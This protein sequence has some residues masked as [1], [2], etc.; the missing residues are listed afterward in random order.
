MTIIHQLDS[1][2]KPTSVAIIGA[3]SNPMKL[4]NWITVSAL[5]SK[6]KGKIY[7]VNPNVKEIQGVQTFSS[8]LDVPGE[9]DVAAIMVPADLVPDVMR[10]C[11]KKKV[12]GV[13]IFSAGFKEIGEK[14]KKREE[15][16]KEL[17]RKGN[18]RIVGPNCMGVYSAAV[19]LNLTSLSTHK[20]V[21]AFVSQS[22]GYGLEIFAAGMQNGIMFSKF[23]STGDKADIQDHEYLEYLY[24]DPDTKV[25][26]LY[27]EGIEKGRD[28][29]DVAKKVTQKKPIFAI[30]IGRS[31]VGRTAA[32]S[33]TGAL[34]GEEE[35]YNA[36]FKQAGIIRASDIE[37][38]FDY[39]R[40]Y[41]TQPL[42]KGNRV[43]ILVGSGGVGVTAADAC[44]DG[45]LQVPPL[46]K[47][48]QEILRAV[49][50]EFASVRNPVDFTGS[51]AQQLFG[52]WG[53]V[54]EI[55][56]DPTIDSWF[57]S[58]PGAGF[59]G[60]QDIVK[61]YEPIMAGLQGLSR[62]E[63]FGRDDAPFVA[64]GNEKDEIIK[65]LLEKLLGLLYYPTPERAIRSIA[66]LHNY[67]RFLEEAKM[68]EKP[69]GIKKDVPLINQILSKSRL[70]HRRIL[71]EIESKQ[72][73]SA[74]QIPTTKVLLA[75][76]QQEAVTL[77]KQ[78][79]F[80]VVLKIV[81]PDITHKT[82]AE[83]VYLH[84][85]N[86]QQVIDAYQQ[87]IENAKRFNPKASVHGVA[88][89]KMVSQGTEVIIGIKRDPQFG[90]VI[91]FG[92]GGILVELFKDVSLRLV[93]INTRDA[94][95]MIEEIKLHRLFDGY[96]SFKAIDKGA[97]VSLLMKVS[98]LA[99][100]VPSIE[101]MD[102]N[103]VFLYPDGAV[104][105]DARI[106]LSQSEG[107]L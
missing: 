44:A 55:F 82:D 42:P 88:V 71:T 63:I 62:A 52:N 92:V 102:L 86:E 100:Q 47:G 75:R 54:R 5:N 11:I 80:P 89:Q 101:E 18:M 106:I 96:R 38:L 35:V 105:V 8:I 85:E 83:G 73:L 51:G 34:A 33:H 17:A 48:N 87:I 39:L 107:T 67:K 21:V 15:E 79:G 95:R 90:P 81:S 32:Q 56:T 70:E 6:F 1:I 49:L 60:I 65:P 93:P 7:L 59:S 24:D 43:G 2:F 45:G 4:N 14:G 41:L 28:F 69:F 57:F 16:I 94:E 29:F 31:D 98:A 12:K 40:A 30:K 36:A 91:L 46:S 13:I 84:L 78:V 50:P 3:S 37:E 22:G 53:D 66:V 68:D 97:L 10:D 77:A 19:N 99:K 9:I 104:V 26:V 23:I 27:L 20:G 76:T 103:P 61:S 58:F 74:F 25:I 64:A 72:L